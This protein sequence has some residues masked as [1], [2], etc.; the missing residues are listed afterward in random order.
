MA[1]LRATLTHYDSN[2][3]QLHFTRQCASK[4]R[5]KY[6]PAKCSLDWHASKWCY[7]TRFYYIWNNG[8]RG[9]AV[10]SEQWSNWLLE[11]IIFPQETESKCTKNVR[12]II[13]LGLLTVIDVFNRQFGSWL[14]SMTL[15]SLWKKFVSPGALCKTCIIIWTLVTLPLSDLF[16]KTRSAVFF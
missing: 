2:M 10:F 7:T 5:P 3:C 9:K 8:W 15:F 13:P 1:L 14:Y 6:Q 12:Y 16:L 4:H 11:Q